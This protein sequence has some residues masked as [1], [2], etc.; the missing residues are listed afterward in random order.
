MRVARSQAIRIESAI[1]PAKPNRR[2]YGAI[3]AP[4][5]SMRIL[6]AH[7]LA[8]VFG[9]GIRSGRRFPR[10]VPWTEAEFKPPSSLDPSVT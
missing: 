5:P 9:P 7:R 3:R 4:Q 6:V 10:N 2:R 8:N 1:R